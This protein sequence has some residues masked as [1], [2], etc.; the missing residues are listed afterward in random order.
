MFKVVDNYLD[1][2]QHII[3]KTIM[4]SNDFPWFYTKGKSKPTNKPKLFDF[5]IFPDDLVHYVLPEKR[6]KKRICYAFNL[7]KLEKGE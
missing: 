6:N 5:I 2:D 4:E 3:L 1:I 7:I